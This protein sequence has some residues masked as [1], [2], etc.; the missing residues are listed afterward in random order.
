MIDNLANLIGTTI[1]LILKAVIYLLIV[2]S[3]VWIA[4]YMPWP[5]VPTFAQNTL[6][7]NS[8]R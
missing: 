7:P 2:W 6:C 5:E 8:W 4:A 1:G 3:T